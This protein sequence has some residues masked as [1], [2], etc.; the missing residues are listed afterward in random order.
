MKKSKNLDSASYH[1][2]SDVRLDTGGE[3][4]AGAGKSYLVRLLS[5]LADDYFTVP[6][7]EVTLNGR[8]LINTGV[9]NFDDNPD[10]GDYYYWGAVWG[11]MVLNNV[12]AGAS[13]PLTPV[14][15]YLDGEQYRYNFDVEAVELVPPTPDANRDGQIALD[16]SDDTSAAKPFRFWIN[17]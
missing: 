15:H 6:P 3:G 8:A 11:A 2:R 1:E 14:T 12:P 17:K 4:R 7:E 16:G 9:T 10:N 13:V 5:V